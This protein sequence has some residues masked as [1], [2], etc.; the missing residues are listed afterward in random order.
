MRR[1]T[2]SCGLRQERCRAAFLFHSLAWHAGELVAVGVVDVLPRCLSS[3]YL[4][5]D[6]DWASLGLGKLTAL[7]EIAWVQAASARC[8]SLRWYHMVSAVKGVLLTAD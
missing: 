2:W 6:P 3:A 4:F 7:K 5:W 8:P 1:S